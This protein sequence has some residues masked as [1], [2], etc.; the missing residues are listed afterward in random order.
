M[1]FVCLG[2][3][4]ET[5]CLTLLHRS[6]TCYLQQVFG[7]AHFNANGEVGCQTFD[8]EGK[9]CITNMHNFGYAF[10]QVGNTT[11][12]VCSWEL[13]FGSAYLEVQTF[14]V[15]F[16]DE[17]TVTIPST[18]GATRKL[19]RG[20]ALSPGTSTIYGVAGSPR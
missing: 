7:E 4:R 13:M 1:C 3:Y 5:K 10:S 2:S 15:E 9:S 17:L 19:L 6:F 8:E 11:S 16:S 18:E 12:Q 14:D 20:L